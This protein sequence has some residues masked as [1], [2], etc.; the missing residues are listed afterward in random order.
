MVSLGGPAVSI[1]CQTFTAFVRAGS[2][3]E[4][5]A[6]HADFNANYK[7]YGEQHDSQAFP[8]SVPHES[9]AEWPVTMSRV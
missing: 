2:S 6:S 9:T 5:L 1:V 4:T 7:H 3:K 8:P